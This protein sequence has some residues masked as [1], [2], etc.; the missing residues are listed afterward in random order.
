MGQARQGKRSS[1]WKVK[2]GITARKSLFALRLTVRTAIVVA[3]AAAIGG[4]V[5]WQIGPCARPL[6]WFDGGF[7]YAASSGDAAGDELSQ[8]AELAHR[9]LKR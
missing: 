6:H 1:D 2:N 9:Q 7:G 5:A 8:I 3:L 4:V